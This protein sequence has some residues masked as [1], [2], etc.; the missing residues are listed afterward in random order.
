ME[1]KEAETKKEGEGWVS[2][3]LMEPALVTFYWVGVGVSPTGVA[4]FLTEPSLF[5]ADWGKISTDPMGSRI[6]ECGEACGFI[7][8]LGFQ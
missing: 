3:S 7:P 2:E 1:A 6:T 4:A 5:R 8:G